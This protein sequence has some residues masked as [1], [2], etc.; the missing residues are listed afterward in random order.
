MAGAARVWGKGGQYRNPSCPH[1]GRGGRRRPHGRQSR[2]QRA[3][4]V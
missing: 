4:A 1:A 2:Q 3:R